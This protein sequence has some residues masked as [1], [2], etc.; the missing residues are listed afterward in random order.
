MIRL[1]HL[2]FLLL[3]CGTVQ[4]Q[5][6][7]YDLFTFNAPKKW[8]KAAKENSLIFS[9]T[10][11]RNNTWAQ[12]DLLK[13]TSSKG[14]IDADFKNEWKDL[15]MTRYGVGGEP[16]AIDSNTHLGWKLYTGLGKFLV[17][18]DTASGTRK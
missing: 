16:L 18:T 10:D 6:Q 9:T 2:S 8:N 13:S 11:N 12:I 5:Q 14:S 4:S 7:T 1:I 17:K 15:V 3:L